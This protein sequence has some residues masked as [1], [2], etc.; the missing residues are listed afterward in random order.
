MLK[1]EHKE[2]L[3]KFTATD[4]RGKALNQEALLKPNI[5]IG[6][7][8]VARVLSM[9]DQQ[10]QEVKNLLTPENADAIKILLPE[11][12]TAIAKGAGNGG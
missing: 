8:L 3:K 1:P 11:L 2:Q 4:H 5:M 9:T 12:A 7:I 10:Q 6:K